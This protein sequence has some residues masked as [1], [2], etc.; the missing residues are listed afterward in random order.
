MQV[1][2]SKA[3]SVFA[4]PS[5]WERRDHRRVGA[6]ASR[7]PIGTIWP[8]QPSDTNTDRLEQSRAGGSAGEPQSAGRRNLGGSDL[9]RP[10]QLPHFVPVHVAKVVH[11]TE[12]R[13]THGAELGSLEVVVR[14]RLVVVGPRRVRIQREFELPVPVEV[15]PGPADLDAW[16]DVTSGLPSL[17][18]PR[19]GSKG[20]ISAV[21]RMRPAPLQVDCV[22]ERVRRPVRPV[23]LPASGG[24]PGSQRP[25]RSG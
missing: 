16:C 19:S 11:G 24:D 9:R 6:T 22:V 23:C 4:P 7:T 2:Y 18:L 17:A 15:E 8:A 25:R 21:R 10:R 5:E 14:E 13:A 12:F 1:S 3:D 20:M